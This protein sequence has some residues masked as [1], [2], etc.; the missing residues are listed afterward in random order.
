[1]AVALLARRF[2]G[3]DARKA[4]DAFVTGMLRDMGHLVLAGRGEPD[5]AQQ[6]AALSAYLLGLWG[7][8]HAVMEAVAFHERPDAIEHDR[9]EV[10]DVVHVAD[11]LMQ[12]WA[13]SPFQTPA[14]LDE[15]RLLRLGMSETS[16]REL[17]RNAERVR[18]DARKM[19]A[20]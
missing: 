17:A 19:L 2:Y 12:P 1:L 16:L 15:A 10:V 20:L 5:D 18:D 8:P 7:I 4:D 9:L 13:P 3:C 6:H 14:A 11:R